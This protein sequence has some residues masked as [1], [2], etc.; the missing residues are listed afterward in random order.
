MVEIQTFFLAHRIKESKWA[1]SYDAEA[2]AIHGIS[3]KPNA[4]WPI[5]LHLHF[6]LQ[7]RRQFVD[8]DEIAKIGMRLLTSDGNVS[9]TMNPGHFER[10][11][12]K[13]NYYSN[14]TGILN[15]A[16]HAEG[17]YY[18]E[19]RILNN[20]IAP[21]FHYYFNVWAPPKGHIKKLASEWRKQPKLKN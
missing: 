12:P 14:T 10:K 13:G 2:V 4:K 1:L 15:I 20:P 6:F 11:I 16:I 3:I 19:F 17:L 18:L 5:N 8:N 21:P 7:L 9:G